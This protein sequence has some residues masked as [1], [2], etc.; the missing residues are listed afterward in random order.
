[1]N[2]KDR[3]KVTSC[4][5]NEGFDYCFCYYSKFPEVKDAEFHELRK[6]YVEAANAL[7]EYLGFD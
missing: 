6:K 1:M 5:E 2:R 4:A 7:K 3:E